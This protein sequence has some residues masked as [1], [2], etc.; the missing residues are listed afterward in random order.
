MAKKYD[1]SNKLFDFIEARRGRLNIKGIGRVLNPNNPNYFADVL[2]DHR[3]LSK[4]YAF[5]IATEMTNFG[6]EIDGWKFDTFDHEYPLSLF[7]MS[8]VNEDFENDETFKKHEIINGGLTHFEYE[9]RYYK[10]DFEV[11][12][13]WDLISYKK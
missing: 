9:R 2:N 7:A 11:D 4:D 5:S 6:L 12:A 10:Q 1:N 3:P 13:F 8:W